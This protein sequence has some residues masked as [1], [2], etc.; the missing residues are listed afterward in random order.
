MKNTINSSNELSTGLIITGF[1]AEWLYGDQWPAVYR[2]GLRV[3]HPPDFH[4]P[5]ADQPV[6]SSEQWQAGTLAQKSQMRVCPAENPANAGRCPPN[7][8]RLRRTLQNR[9]PA[10][11]HRVCHTGRQVGRAGAEN[12]RTTRPKSWPSP[13]HAGGCQGAARFPGCSEH[14]PHAS[15]NAV[16]RLPPSFRHR[17]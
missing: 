13:G 10:Q 3:V 15:E 1:P 12:V 7:G 16:V 4:D 5:W 8:D 9:T 2:P 14:F 6:L 11:R 17:D